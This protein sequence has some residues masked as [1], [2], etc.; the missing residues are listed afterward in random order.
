MNPYQCRQY[1]IYG[2]FGLGGTLKLKPYQDYYAFPGIAHAVNDDLELQL[3]LP[4]FLVGLSN[5]ANTFLL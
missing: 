2:C 4:V 1:H 3:P 5:L